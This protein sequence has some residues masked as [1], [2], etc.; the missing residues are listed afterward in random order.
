VHTDLPKGI[1]FSS[2][3]VVSG[4]AALNV[5]GKRSQPD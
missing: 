1:P 4:G 3:V 2:N 5:I